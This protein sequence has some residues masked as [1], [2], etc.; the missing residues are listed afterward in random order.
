MRNRILF[1]LLAILLLPLIVACGNTG[2]A[3]TGGDNTAATTPASADAT[4][5]PAASEAGDAT[6]APMGTESAGMAEGSTTTT[7]AGVGTGQP[8]KIGM[9]TDIG[10]IDDKSF[11]ES[12]WKGVQMGAEAVGGEAQYIETT[13]PND[14]QRNIDQFVNE[15]YNVIVTVGFLM[16]EATIA[17]AEANPEI[18]FIGVDQFQPEAIPNLVGLIFDEDKAGF[19]AGALAASLTKS[20]KIGAVLGTDTVPP[21]WKF[22][23]GYRAGAQ[24]IKSDINVQTVYH[25]DVPNPFTDPDWG[26]TTALSMF[27]QGV[28]VVFGAGGQ[29]GNGALFA[30]AERK[31]RGVLAIGVDTDQYL[32]I[33]EAQPVLVSSAMKII[34]QGV[35]DLIQQIANG[36]FQGGNFVCKVGLAPF[37]DLEGQVPDDVKAKLEDLRKQLDDGTLKTNVPPAKPS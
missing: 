29:T 23:E 15:N 20:G 2:G 19:L 3:G 18:M 26:R 25:N 14:Y 8:L 24:H 30:A 37:H 36:T 9:V 6:M 10:K 33:P 7:V 32:T 22:G 31:D 12:A 4:Q 35:A 21:V 17:A 27:D 16:S 28:D 34:D 5:A 1:F 13:D 11:N